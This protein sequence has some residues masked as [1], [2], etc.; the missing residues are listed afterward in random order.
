MNVKYLRKIRL[1]QFLCDCDEWKEDKLMYVGLYVRQKS[2]SKQV[3]VREQ[4]VKESLTSK[5]YEQHVWVL[6]ELISHSKRVSLI[7]AQRMTSV[8]NTSML[9]LNVSRTAYIPCHCFLITVFF[10]S[11]CSDRPLIILSSHVHIPL[12]DANIIFKTQEY[13]ETANSIAWES[14]TDTL[15]LRHLHSNQFV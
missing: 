9:K 11:S 14:Q 2:G 3:R 13:N 8:I 10:H 4:V 6:W 15:T 12:Q 7:N 1:N 5:P